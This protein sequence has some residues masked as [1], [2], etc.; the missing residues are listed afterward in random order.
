M[1]NTAKNIIIPKVQGIFRAI[2][3]YSGQ[4]ESTLFVIPDG[5]DY[6]YAL[7]DSNIDESSGGIDILELL[8]DLLGEDGRELDL[9]INTHPHQDHIGLIKKFMM[10]SELSRYGTLGTNLEETTKTHI[11]ILS[12]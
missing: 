11:K 6:I 12:M 10:K 2:F 4:G 3:L 7:I 5:T 9:Y 1:S 8:K